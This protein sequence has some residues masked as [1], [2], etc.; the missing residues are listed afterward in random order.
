MSVSRGYLRNLQ[1]ASPE[2]GLHAPGAGQI[3]R[4]LSFNVQVGI[5][6]SAY[7]QY[8]TR[9]WKHL[10]PHRERQSNLALTSDLLQDFDIV[11]LQEVDG[12]SLRTWRQNQVEQLASQAGFNY[13]YQQLNRDLA[14]FAQ[15]SNGLLSRFTPS[16]IEDHALPGPK[17]RGAI[18]VRY[19][20]GPSSLAIIM[21][22]LALG[23]RVRNLQL[24]YI[25]ELAS[26]YRHCVLMGDMNTHTDDLLYRSPLR[27]LDL[28]AA[29]TCATFPSWKP[30]RCLDHIL[31]SP[32]L[33]AS[34]SRVVAY[35]LSDHLPVATEIRLPDSF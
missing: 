1:P 11:A 13:W 19:G 17:G 30:A 15:H 14:P 9:C 29:Q 26:D 25:R 8:L 20:E 4:L 18:L 7:H 31:L 10:L 12:G 28:S 33:E 23:S 35:P 21:M 5:R 34:H 2:H 22:H 32:E 3:L 16:Q 24:G 27:G 6:T